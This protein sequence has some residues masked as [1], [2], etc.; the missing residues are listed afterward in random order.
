MSHENKIGA[1][2]FRQVAAPGQRAK[3]Y[4]TLPPAHGVW[5][6]FMRDPRSGMADH[7]DS[8]IPREMAMGSSLTW[9]GNATSIGVSEEW[10][11]EWINSNG[12]TGPEGPQGSVGPVGPK[13]DKG[14]AG[15][16]GD[17]GS[18]GAVGPKGDKGDTGAQ[19]PAGAT[20]STG[21]Q[22][23][24]GSQGPKGDTG[25]TGATGQAGAPAT[26]PAQLIGTT[27]LNE[28]AVVVIAAGVRKANLTISGVTPGNNY[29]L[30]PTAATPAG[31]VLGDV[32]CTANNTLQVSFT[33]PL[34]AIGQNISITFRCVRIVT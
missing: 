34:I 12:V 21:A 7:P 31:F 9:D 2:R 29:L 33:G 10:L 26:N 25:A 28:T 3:T 19:G 6:F 14:D 22:G 11:A 27:T 32:V 18:S 1:F 13:G 24:T 16:K 17:Q 8:G 20:G 15:A 30:F 23:A 4:D 5:T